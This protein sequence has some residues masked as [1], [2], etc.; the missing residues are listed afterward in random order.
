MYLDTVKIMR[1]TDVDIVKMHFGMS[2]TEIY[3]KRFKKM[4]K[5][6][7]I[8]AV[9]LVLL[10]LAV[11]FFIS[12][13][14]IRTYTEENS[15]SEKFVMDVNGAPNGF[16]INGVD[17]NNPVLLLVSSGPGTDDYVFTEKYKDM[18]LEEDF[19]VVYWD[20]RWMGIAYSGNADKDSITL[21]NLL[22]DAKSVTDYLKERF[23]KEK[24]YIMGFS[25]GSHIALRAAQQHPED[26]YAYIGMAQVVTDS[27]DRDTRMYDFMKQTFEERGA[28]GSLKTLENAVEHL[29]DGRVRCK[30]WYD[31]VMLVHD[32]GG[33]TILD[34]SEFSGIVWPIITCRCYTVSE[35]INY[36]RG[37]KMYRTTPLSDELNGFD[38][39]QSL[40]ELKVPAYFISGEKDYNCPW[41]LVEEYC[42]DLS[43]PDKEFIKIPNAAHSPLWENPQA[44]CEFLRKVKEKCG[45]SGT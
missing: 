34:K 28:K 43:A 33:G 26:Y 22:E 3:M 44:T 2:E 4:I 8:V 14:K 20:Y 32:A 21:A 35:K 5:W 36:I 27:E 17:Q 1:Y 23:G 42:E 41:E 40:R 30:D 15:I 31:Y 18:R 7:L 13:G 38:Y 10:L 45:A 6:I 12:S 11:W 16:F 9:L 25:G 39:R 24:I 19:T 29:E 37:M